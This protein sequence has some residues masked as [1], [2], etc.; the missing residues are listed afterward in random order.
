M[1]ESLYTL[2]FSSSTI[3]EQDRAVV[4]RRFAEKTGTPQN[5]VAAIFSS[6]KPVRLLSGLD[7]KKARLLKNKLEAIGMQ[8][9]LEVEAPIV[10]SELE[11]VPMEEELVNDSGQTGIGLGEKEELTLV[12]MEID[13]DVPDQERP[14][15]GKNTFF[16]PKCGTQQA[17]SEQCV[18][19]SIFFSKLVEAKEEQAPG[20]L[21][22]GT[23]KNTDKP[24]SF[25]N[26]LR[27]V[28][29]VIGLVAGLGGGLFVMLKKF[30]LFKVFFAAASMGYV[31]DYAVEESIGLCLGDS[32][33]EVIVNDKAADCWELSGMDQYDWDSMS[34]NEYE[35][36]YQELET[37]FFSCFDYPDG[38]K[39]FLKPA[40]LTAI[41]AEYC[42]Y[43]ESCLTL[44]R[45]QQWY[46][47]ESNELDLYASQLSELNRSDE[48]FKTY[49]DELRGFMKCFVDENHAQLFPDYYFDLE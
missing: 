33:C 42:S 20:S 5:K 16:C 45:H 26:H 23:E 43:E 10:S 29:G 48:L 25:S 15:L 46:C 14:A 6:S 22:L 28:K 41:L 44:V 31:F 4:A 1:D 36:R 30:G 17:R 12:P 9:A 27:S 35:R 19:C 32:Q 38:R 47:Y 11:L 37:S 24:G 3:P 40:Y 8:I 34:E 39:L 18:S 2:Y 49:N 21:A 7:G 13:T